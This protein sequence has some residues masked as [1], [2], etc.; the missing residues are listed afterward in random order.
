MSLALD[1]TVGRLVAENPARARVFEKHRID[2]CCGGKLPLAEACERRK[3]DYATVVA[4]LESID[5]AGAEI[6]PTN[7]DQALLGELA[8]HIVATH[9][10]YLVEELP[11]LDAMCARVAK[12]HGHHAPEVVELYSV[13]VA[14]RQELEE[15]A[16][17]EEQVL[18]PWIKRMEAGEL[19][20]FNASVSNPIRCMENEHEN[21]GQALGR[22]RELTNG[23]QPP[24]DACNT[25]RVLYASLEA[26]EQDMHTH[27]HKEN[28]ILFPRAL[29]LESELQEDAPRRIHL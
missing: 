21:A 4:D 24:E 9:H 18:F 19:G 28:S 8:D 17:K 11:R 20:P 25:W 27:V 10:A 2:Y 5:S 1:S 7:W 15:H 16:T 13:F 29:Q 23:F 22:F 6:V 26:L 12:V 3:V 14:F